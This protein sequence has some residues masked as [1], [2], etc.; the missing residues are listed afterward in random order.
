MKK[1][2][3]IFAILAIVLI[4]SNT[5]AQTWD[6]TVTGNVSIDDEGVP[7]GQEG[8]LVSAYSMNYAEDWSWE[9]TTTGAEGNYSLLINYPE[10][11]LTDSLMVE[12][13]DA[14]GNYFYQILAVDKYEQTG[15]LAV[16]EVCSDPLMPVADFYWTVNP[17][18]LY[19]INFFDYTFP[20][21]M[22][23]N[24]E[25]DFGD[26]QT[27][28]EP[29]PVHMYTSPDTYTVTLTVMDEMYYVI[30]T[31]AEDVYVEDYSAGEGWA[32][33]GYWSED[34]YTYNFWNDSW[35]FQDEIST[36]DWDFGDGTTFSGEVPPAHT[37]TVAGDYLVTM[38]ILTTGGYEYHAEQIIWVGDE[39]WYPED[40]EALFYTI[41][42]ED[43]SISFQNISWAGTGQQIVWQQWDF[44]DGTHMTSTNP[45]HTYENTDNEYIVTLTIGT[46]EGCES[47]FDVFVYPGEY[48]S[49]DGGILFYPAPAL[50]KGNTNLHN[51]SSHDSDSWSWDY[52]DTKGSTKTSKDV[53]SHDYSPGVYIATLTENN[54]Q[55]G[56]AMRIKVTED[57]VE[58]LQSYAISGNQTE[59]TEFSDFN[60]NNITIYP[61][62]VSDYLNINF[63][64]EAE[65]VN[66]SIVNVAG[67]IIYTN[68]YTNQK[69]T[70]IDLQN[71]QK[72]MYIIKINA[73]GQETNMKFIK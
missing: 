53:H 24:I 35:Y 32:D 43:G 70:K 14:C 73:D 57:D 21:G 22:P 39:A 66:I 17:Y 10:E 67:Q 23:M 69:L 58:I 49:A 15:G 36:I 62:P 65:N 26:G 38:D 4:S 6:F 5:Y 25:W 37:Y 19:K 20:Q 52:G 27:G 40:C 8:M 9:E 33:F 41:Y 11:I 45:T 3:S 47:S 34:F 54:T 63:K 55:E 2:L 50:G 1:I 71:L 61:N 60:K 29:A 13:I 30:S 46:F 31:Y 72:G 12:I 42:N 7:V 64:E 28:Y 68:D 48:V 44:G 59:I 16:F 51:I 18:D 56:F